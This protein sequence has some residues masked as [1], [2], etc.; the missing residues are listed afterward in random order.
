VSDPKKQKP[1]RRVRIVVK[2]DGRSYFAPSGGGDLIEIN[3]QTLN[4]ALLEKHLEIVDPAA[5]GSNESARSVTQ[6]A[7]RQNV[8]PFD[9]KKYRDKNLLERMEQTLHSSEHV[10]KEDDI[11]LFDTTKLYKEAV[12][13]TQ[14]FIQSPGDEA[15]R[16]E[17]FGVTQLL[18]HALSK[19]GR[20]NMKTKVSLLRSAIENNNLQE[21]QTHL[22]GLKKAWSKNESGS[23][24]ADESANEILEIQAEVERAF[25]DGDFTL[26][27]HLGR[28]EAFCINAYENGHF[29]RLDHP[30]HEFMD[31]WWSWGA[32]RPGKLTSSDHPCEHFLDQLSRYLDTRCV[33]NLT[34]CKDNVRF[35]KIVNYLA[36]RPPSSQSD[37]TTAPAGDSTTVSQQ[38]SA[39]GGNTKNKKRGR[40]SKHIEESMC[41]LWR[42]WRKCKGS[43]PL[44]EWLRDKSSDRSYNEVRSA[45]KILDSRAREAKLKKDS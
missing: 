34:E 30:L 4:Q 19:R 7:P 35:R 18:C 26:D 20:L 11:S 15:A 22:D 42:D 6:N 25:D 24:T 9:P 29:K 33:N 13:L 41:G 17:A 16:S 1:A 38:Q 27:M 2:R 43:M 31:F 12:R 8:Q 10:A 5:A 45:F 14:K 23:G 28:L 40:P 3:S 32:V 37:L 21:C 36:S 44:K 39:Q